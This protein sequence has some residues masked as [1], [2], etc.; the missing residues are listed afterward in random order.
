MAIASPALSARTWAPS[1]R[2]VPRSA[3][4]LIRPRVSR[5]TRARD[6]G[7]VQVRRAGRFAHYQ[8][9]DPRVAELVMLARSLAADNVDALA[10]CLRIDT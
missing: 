2:P 1:S 8:V 6:C 3:T 10:N 4:S 9:T 7:Y 5:L